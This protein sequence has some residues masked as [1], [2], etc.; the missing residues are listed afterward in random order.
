MNEEGGDL[1][2]QWCDTVSADAKATNCANC[3]AALILRESFDGIRVPGLTEV[4][5]DLKVYAKKPLR[6]PRGSPSQ[7]VAGTAVAAAALGGPAALLGLGALGATVVKEYVDA[8]G[9]KSPPK[10]RVGVP[11]EAIVEMV[12]KLNAEAL[13]KPEA[14]V[15][16]ARPE[17]SPQPSVS[18]DDPLRKP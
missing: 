11:S 16:A 5:P 9:G 14:E 15:T 7:A 3:G 17:A 10:D 2:C 1:R 6:I 12:N 4:D 8:G 18:P 13:A